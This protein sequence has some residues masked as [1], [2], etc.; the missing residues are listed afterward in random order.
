VAGWP[1]LLLLLLLLLLA[2][3]LDGSLAA[4]VAA[5]WLA[6]YKLQK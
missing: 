3:R 1:L 6:C 2:G 4:T 5:G